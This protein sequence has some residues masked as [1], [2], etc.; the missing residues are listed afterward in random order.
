MSKIK[1]F[2]L[3]LALMVCSSAAAQ[4]SNT[5]AR[6]NQR[7][8]RVAGNGF[9]SNGPVAGY[10]GFIDL[11][12]TIG[13]GDFGEGR[14]SF[15]TT[16][17]YQINSYFFAGIGTGVNY[18]HKSEAWGIPIYADFRGNLMNNGISPFIDFK[19]GYSVV[20]AEGFFLSPSVGCRFA[21]GEKSGL[22]ISVGYEMQKAK[23]EVSTKYFSYSGNENCG[24]VVLKVGIDF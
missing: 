15:M 1:F 21:I 12:Y 8:S 16:H 17:G 5:N 4:F 19:I 6:G 18:F 22:N 24:G 13:A 2:I 3:S 20:D 7:S 11:G 23:W 9:D 14:I 10:K